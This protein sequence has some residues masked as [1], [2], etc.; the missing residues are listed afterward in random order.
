ML[1]VCE[2]VICEY[3]IWES[4]G[5]LV[6]RAL[7]TRMRSRKLNYQTRVCDLHQIKIFI[8]HSFFHWITHTRG[9]L[10]D[11]IF[12]ANDDQ[13]FNIGFEIAMIERCMC[14]CVACARVHTENICA[15]NT[16]CT[17][18]RHIFLSKHSQYGV[19]WHGYC[20]VSVAVETH[21]EQQ[22]TQFVWWIEIQA[23][24]ATTMTKTPINSN[25]K[26]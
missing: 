26:K 3:V 8:L 22:H 5:R 4:V 25:N 16:E 24:K 2:Y 6:G 19:F 18:N 12:F 1:S 23:N 9:G 7:R 21:M 10:Q 11:A 13:D 14:E 15:K 20:V 17:W